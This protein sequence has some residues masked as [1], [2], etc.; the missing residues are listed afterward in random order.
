MLKNILAPQ[1]ELYWERKGGR[2]SNQHR[3]TLTP[4]NSKNLSAITSNTHHKNWNLGHVPY[5]VCRCSEQRTIEETPCESGREF[6]Q[7]LLLETFS[8]ERK[9]EKEKQLQKAAI[10]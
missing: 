7:K 5:S 3:K 10:S 4:I 9:S 2:S 8:E 1:N 6:F